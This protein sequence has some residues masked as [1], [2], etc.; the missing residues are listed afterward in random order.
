VAKSPHPSQQAAEARFL[1]NV[2]IAIPDSGLGRRLIE[3]MA[4]CRDRMMADEWDSHTHT[5]R[6]PAGTPITSVRFYFSTEADAAAF[7]KQWGT[8][9]G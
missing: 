7:K 5:Q 6:T 4:W 8:D 9:P 3:M 2:D 1:R